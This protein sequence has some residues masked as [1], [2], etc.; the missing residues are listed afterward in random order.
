MYGTQPN[1][2]VVFQ[3]Y[4]AVEGIKKE[5]FVPVANPFDPPTKIQS[6]QNIEVPARKPAEL[7]AIYINGREHLHFFSFWTRIINP[8]KSGCHSRR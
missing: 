4:N 5:S 7:N 1:V 3:G 8:E 2:A 6:T